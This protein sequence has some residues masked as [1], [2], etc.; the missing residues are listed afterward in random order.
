L[1]RGFKASAARTR[2][3]ARLGRGREHDWDADASTTRTRTFLWVT[4]V[5]A[6]GV[7]STR[8]RLAGRGR[9]DNV[10]TLEGRELIEQAADVILVRRQDTPGKLPT[11]AERPDSL[12]LRFGDGYE[13]VLSPGGEA[14]GVEVRSAR[15][16][17]HLESLGV[18]CKEPDELAT[19]L[20]YILQRHAGPEA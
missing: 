11:R 20:E 6:G 15:T 13:L 7:M 16:G 17:A 9:S 3:G 10:P 14:T 4:A 1:L 18:V 2:T 5:R 8:R 12:Q 19:E